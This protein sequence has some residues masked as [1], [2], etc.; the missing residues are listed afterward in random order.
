MPSPRCAIAQGS[1]PAAEV[2]GEHRYGPIHYGPD[3]GPPEAA[4]R[5]LL[6]SLSFPL[7]C[8][9]TNISSAHPLNSSDRGQAPS[10]WEGASAGCARS[11]RP[12]PA[13]AAPAAPAPARLPAPERDLL[14]EKRERHPTPFP[15][16][17]RRRPF[18]RVCSAFVGCLPPG[19]GASSAESDHSSLGRFGNAL[20][21]CPA[22]SLHLVWMLLPVLTRMQ[23]FM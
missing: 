6:T 19:A 12:P 22:R 8:N 13:P 23:N 10:P 1:P 18:A 15:S 5:V 16:P 17:C 20:E 7:S 2:G 11:P 3:P 21:P 4:G 9:R 14:R